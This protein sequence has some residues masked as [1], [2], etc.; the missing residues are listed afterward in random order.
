MADGAPTNTTTD[1]LP[2]LRGV[3]AVV[4]A[5][6]AAAAAA[7][8]ELSPAAIESSTPFVGRWNELVSTT[9]WEKG[10]IISE[11]RA[12][13]E[14]GSAAVTEYSDEA[15]ARLVGS[16]T[17][18]HVGRLRR[19]HGR[20]G[21][22]YSQYPGLYW[23]HFQAALDWPDAEMWLEGAI[24][25]RWSVSQMR[26][27][28]WEAVG[29]PDGVKPADE[30]I[31]SAEIDEDAYHEFAEPAALSPAEP[32]T[33]ADGPADRSGDG[34]GDGSG[35]GDDEDYPAAS[36]E[37]SIEEPWAVDAAPRVRPFE[38]LAELPDDVAEAFEQFK[39]VIL[40]HKLAGWAE[41][42]RSDILGVL[43]SLKQLAS[44]PT[45]AD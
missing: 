4:T 19:V 6:A 26:G 20:F 22:L 25:N 37:P 21:E 28:R 35:S 1:P 31:V 44:A 41:V 8:P 24:T 10:R 11:W 39:L 3:E 15:W 43:D 18:Q 32:A 33:R 9:N 30:E 36:G 16:V 23:S 27:A 2:E 29:A 5:P 17:S 34:P 7:E 38:D 40:N 14:A 45:D 12:A 42:S 13:L